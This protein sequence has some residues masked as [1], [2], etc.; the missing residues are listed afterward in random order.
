MIIANSDICKIVTRQKNDFEWYWYWLNNG[1]W[2]TTDAPWEITSPNEKEEIKTVFNKG[3]DNEITGLR[4][5]VWIESNNLRI[6]SLNC[7][8]LNIEKKSVKIGIGIYEPEYRGLGIAK[9]A[10]KLWV[11]YI[12]ENF[13]ILRIELETYDFNISM[14]K[15][16]EKTGFKLEKIENNFIEWKDN[17]IDKY[18]FYI[19]RVDINNNL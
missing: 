16:A 17:K 18:F 15:V 2:R 14:I 11:K 8:G 4:T 13:D 9:T 3:I 10:I 19:N 6:G 1:D 12:F 5:R 7:Y